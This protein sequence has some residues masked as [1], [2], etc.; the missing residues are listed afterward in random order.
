MYS[1][2]K[3]DLDENTVLGGVV[4]HLTQTAKK[5]VKQVAKEPQEIAKDAGE[6][7]VSRGSE[8]KHGAKEKKAWGSDE[9]RERYLRDLYG[10]TD[11]SDSGQNKDQDLQ[12]KDQ[13]PSE[14]EKQIENKPPEEQKKLLELRQMLHKSVYYDPT[15]ERKKEENEEERAQE[16]VEKEKKME[17]LELQEK[18]KEKPPALAV[19]RAQ[20]KA[21]MFPGAAG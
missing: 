12:S 9:E 19:Q 1:L 16:K 21:E 15:F 20:N 7:V 10:A 6:Q 18:D 14:F 8:E 2:M 13:K 17:E 4:S 11:S 5:A 3:M